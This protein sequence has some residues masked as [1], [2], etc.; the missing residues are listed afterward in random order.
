MSSLFFGNLLLAV[1]RRRTCASGLPSPIV[2]D[3]T[4]PRS[5]AILKSPQN[6]PMQVPPGP[7]GTE[8]LGFFGVHSAPHTLGFLQRTAHRF[9]PFSYFRLLSQRIY[10]VNDADIVKDVLITRQ[11]AFTRDIGAIILRELVG[12]GLITRD[13]PQHRE[14]R[15][16]LQPAFHREQIA[17]Y[18]E[19]MSAQTAEVLSTWP[20]GISLDM[21]V[22]MRRITLAIIGSTLFGPEFRES[23]SKVSGVL[24]RV[25]K[26][27]GRIAPFVSL[28]KPLTRGYRRVFPEGRSLFF[29]TER[30]AL[31]RILHPLIVRR[32]GSTARDVLSLLLAL[33]DDPS[34]ALADEAIRN[35]I[36][37]FVLAG[38]ETTASALTWAC[39][40][41][42]RNMDVQ[43]R[44]AAE[45][46]A[47]LGDRLPAVDDVPQLPYASSVFAETL[48]L[49]PPVPVFGRRTVQS[50][51][52]AGY[53]VP[54]GASVLLSTYITSRDER[55]FE[56]PEVFDPDRWLP[57]AAPPHKFAS[58]PFGGGSKMCIGD[59][60][61][62]TEGTLILA[63]LARRF[64]LHSD[65]TAEIG[66][67]GR[68]GTLQPATPVLLKAE[69]R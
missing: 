43:D 67:A 60:F 44:L 65:N 6:V 20:V 53:T 1:S 52:I 31:D 35:E 46:T 32:R 26:R 23:A 63:S 64:R 68:G 61:A 49:Y 66:I 3:R 14:R 42:S 22:E 36:V 28:G 62:K 2:T 11:A 58:F 9:G 33:Q 55:Y 8:L 57:G 40:L 34:S 17:S 38:H 69:P 16:Q 7:R 24:Q 56:N 15:R 4:L 29:A 50:L 41:L 48:R 12:D 5:G 10:L 54:Q 37:T 30:A 21:S 25:V 47:V 51:E 45:A 18:V 59:V 39:Y 19:T 13:E 27:A